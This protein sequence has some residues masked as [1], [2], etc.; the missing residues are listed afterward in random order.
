MFCHQ[1]STPPRSNRTS[2]QAG[3]TGGRSPRCLSQCWRCGTVCC[4]AMRSGPSRQA[5]PLTHRG[6]RSWVRWS[7]STPTVG[8]KSGCTA[9]WPFTTPPTSRAGVTR[10]INCGT[11]GA[12]RAPSTW[13]SGTQ[14]TAGDHSTQTSPV[15]SPSA[16]CSNSP[17][18]QAGNVHPLMS[19]TCSRPPLT[20]PP[21]SPMPCHPSSTRDQRRWSSLWTWGFCPPSWRS[22]LRR[23]G[24]QSGV[25]QRSPCGQAWQRSVQRSIIGPRSN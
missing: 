13:V 25:I 23:S 7:P 5:L 14:P 18:T 6:Q 8:E 12:I 16:P 22:V 24:H 21:P 15:A 11:S 9:A 3:A 10:G 17:V 4:S 19:L 20:P 2:G 1:V